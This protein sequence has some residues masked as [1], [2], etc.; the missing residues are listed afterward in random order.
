MRHHA[1]QHDEAENQYGGPDHPRHDDLQRRNADGI[2]I[3]V[4]RFAD[5]EKRPEYRSRHLQYSRLRGLSLLMRLAHRRSPST[6]LR[7]RTLDPK[8][9]VRERDR[10]HI[11]GQ[12]GLHH[13]Y[14][15]HLAR[16]IGLQFLAREAEAFELLEVAP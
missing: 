1:D 14:H 9:R 10:M 12:T 2:A 16:L 13:E 6:G 5:A 8:E 11:G 15:R 4:A 7:T 3:V